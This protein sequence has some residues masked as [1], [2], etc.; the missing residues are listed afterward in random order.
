MKRK[1]IEFPMEHTSND[2]PF[3]SIW[4][5]ITRTTWIYTYNIEKDPASDNIQ[6]ESAL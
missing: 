3:F 4:K 1:L 5:N 6:N 2:R